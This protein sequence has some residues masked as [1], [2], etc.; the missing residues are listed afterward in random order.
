MDIMLKETS[1]VLPK[2]HEI[3]IVPVSKDRKKPLKILGYVPQLDATK[4][5]ISSIRYKKW[6][7]LRKLANDFEFPVHARATR[8]ISRAFFKL[9]EVIIDQR[10]DAN[11]NTLHLAEAPGGFIEATMNY[12]LK[13][14]NELKCLYTFSLHDSNRDIP[15]YHEKINSEK[16]VIVLSNRENKGDLYSIRNI[17]H[18]IGTLKGKQIKFITCDGGFTEKN[19]FA[20]KEQ[21]H[22]KLIF[23]QIITSL[24]ILEINGCLVIKFFDIFTELSFDFVYILSY[25]FDIV[26]V[27][28]PHT[29]RPTNSEKYI[30]CKFFSQ[31]KF[32]K[33]SKMLK[34]ICISGIEKYSSIID[35]TVIRQGFVA[36]LRK[37]NTLLS[38]YQIYCI[39]NILNVHR[40]DLKITNSRQN[41]NDWISKYIL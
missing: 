8:P 31:Q 28:K 15:T 33:I 13:M 7:N 41:V 19:D 20:S 11:C 39:E 38:E 22:H 16:R 18:L 14:Y 9:T 12:K 37:I 35:K 10:L 25:L 6:T 21:L 5:K 34:D 3:S 2:V 26:M 30:V 29:S 32:N 17:Q 23:H 40:L 36:S 4:D 24:F 1:F 27:C